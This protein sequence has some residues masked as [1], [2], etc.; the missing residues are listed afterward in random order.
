MLL[1][2]E[3]AP[4]ITERFEH[5]HELL[6]HVLPRRRELGGTYQGLAKA[7]ARH[8]VTLVDR[9][10]QHLR[11]ESVLRLGG[12]VRRHG[13]EAVAIDGS[14]FDAPRTIDNERTL[15]TAGKAGTHPQLSV[16]TAWH[17]GTGLPWDWRVGP[18][19]EAERTHL[20]A[21][22]PDLP[23]GCL[24]VTDAGFTGYEL[25]K[26]IRESGREVLVRVGSNV[27]L[28]TCGTPHER[29][30]QVGGRV[31]LSRQD[32]PHEPPLRLRLIVVGKGKKKVYLVTSLT[33]PRQLSK[34]A[35][36]ELYQ[37]RWGVE[38]FYRQAKQTLERRKVRSTSAARAVLEMHWT[39]IGVWVLML[40]TASGLGR[41][42]VDPVRVGAA[43][44]ARTVRRWSRRVQAC[45]PAGRVHRE[46]GRCVKDDAPR[47]GR[48]SS[49]EWPNKKNPPRPGA[50]R[51]RKARRTQ[52]QADRRLTRRRR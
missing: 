10:K 6:N 13:V 4:A 35:A 37:M 45:G 20:R 8:G 36:G 44:A 43:A 5:V 15:G 12:W 51:L 22:L 47:R 49:S 48:K 11:R 33:D 29:V 19:R 39:L 17:M 38:V 23:A 7:L 2:W 9:V 21:M 31:L 1:A 18:A 25:L 34:A 30:R 16:T 14:K 50:P 52:L 42:G 46:L 41:R 27:T 40:M 24:I 3:D 26:S 32:R 28:L